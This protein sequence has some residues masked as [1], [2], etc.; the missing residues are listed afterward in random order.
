MTVHN[1]D[2]RE[3]F[4]AG[5]PI[6]GFNIIEQIARSIGADR[7]LRQSTAMRE[8]IGTDAEVPQNCDLA[9]GRYR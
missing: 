5:N 4:F 3:R 8:M 9:T 7:N 6:C 1:V 2:Y